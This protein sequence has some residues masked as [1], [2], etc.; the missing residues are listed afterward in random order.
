MPSFVTVSGVTTTS[1]AL[2]PWDSVPRAIVA[3]VLAELLRTGNG[4]HQALGL[5]SGPTPVADAVQA[6]EQDR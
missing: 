5:I 1:P 3:A 4:I 6:L 2:W